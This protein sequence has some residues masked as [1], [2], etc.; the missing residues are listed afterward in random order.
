MNLRVIILLALFFPLVSAYDWFYGNITLFHSESAYCDVDNY[1]TRNYSGPLSGFITTTSIKDEQH[2]THGYIGYQPITQSIAVV[3]RGS[4]SVTNWLSDLDVA[5]T[6]Y[7]N[8]E[9]C[10]VHKGFYTAEQAVI[11]QVKSEVS[12]LLKM[13]P[14]YRVLVTGHSLGAALA[15]L[16]AADLKMS[17]V[18]SISLF[19]YGSPRVGNT[20]FASF[21][22]KILGND[23]NRIT[24]HKDIVPHAPM[25]ER[26]THIAGEY[27]QPDDSI[28]LLVC[29]G[30]EDPKC[31]FQWYVTSIEDHL[32][33]L[34]VAMGE[35]E[36]ACSQVLTEELK[37]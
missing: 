2:D 6:D 32:H 25:H 19:N 7:P 37:D 10:E 9:D 28:T 15:T 18:D 11:P 34:G 33:Y 16:T 12:N 3:F 35:S 21:Y 4:E 17:G 29:H 30:Y 20:A 27:Y 8:C 5:M 1:L 31:S 14:N 36:S 13:Y 22:S 26:F 23:T 24:H